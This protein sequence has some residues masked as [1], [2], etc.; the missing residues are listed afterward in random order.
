MLKKPLPQ[1]GLDWKPDAYMLEAAT[2]LIERRSAGLFLDPGLGKT[3]ITLAVYKVLKARRKSKGMIV[4]AP[5]RPARR[6]WPAER[7][8]W[9]DFKD[10]SMAVLHG[11]FKEHLVKKQFDIYVIN[12]EGLQWLIDN[13]HLRALLKNGWVDTIVF[14]ELTKMKNHSSLRFKNLRP[15]LEKFER[16]YGLTGSPAANGLMGLFGECYTLDLGKTFGGLITHWRNQFFE[17]V[18]DY[19]WEPK[20][21]AT[22]TIFKKAAPLALRMKAED[23]MQLPELIDHFIPVDL[24]DEAWR[25]YEEMEEEMLTM[26]EEKLIVAANAG[27]ATA[28]C[29]QICSGAIYH[30]VVDP[31]TGEPTGKRAWSHIHDEKLDA[32]EELIDELHGQQLLI[33]YEFQ[34]EL[35]RFRKRLE[36]TY[37]KLIVMG[38]GIS[39]RREAEIERDWNRGKIPFLFGHPQSIGHGMNLQESSAYN[40]LWYTP[41]YNFE[42]WDQYIRRLRRRGSTAKRIINHTIVVPKTVDM[43]AL[44]TLQK[45]DS[46]QNAFFK[47]ITEYH[48]ARRGK[49][50]F[51]DSLDALIANRQP[52]AASRKRTQK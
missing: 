20:P 25:R 42:L 3:S 2:F 1:S 48:A 26:I 31:I 6:V 24:P 41:T 22:D 28:K 38:S 46:T 40:V 19:V 39:E 49:G 50:L 8:K 4:V 17:R 37:G 5:L 16:R 29:R 45:R 30:A 34:H 15:F 52:K 7:N 12:Y 18:A 27:V 43:V 23:Y 13:H 51:P 36:K 10:L 33:A 9:K 21:G 14:D 47:S 35:E 32:L 11:K 44:R